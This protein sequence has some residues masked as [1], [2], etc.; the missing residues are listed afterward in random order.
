MWKKKLKSH[1]IEAIPQKCLYG[2]VTTWT[3]RRWDSESYV[4]Q[5]AVT[6]SGYD[7]TE[8][9]LYLKIWLVAQV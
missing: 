7:I 6:P 8:A 9:G 2:V 5:L 3:E 1:K 4:Q